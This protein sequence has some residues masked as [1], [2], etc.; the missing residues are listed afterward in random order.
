MASAAKRFRTERD[1]MGELR[2][3]ADAL[4]GA[5]T[6]RAV[7]NFPMSGR[8]MPRGFIRALGLIKASAAS[9]TPTSVCCRRAS[10]RRSTPP[11]CRSPRRARRAVPD[12]HLP[13]RLRH[14]V[15]HERQRGHRQRSRLAPPARQ[16]HPNDHVNLGQSS[17]DVIPTA[18]HVSAQLAI[19]RGPAAGAEAPARD[20]RPPRPKTFGKVV[21]TGRTHL[22]DA[23]PLTFAQEFGAWSAQLSS[24]QARIEDALQAPAPPADRRHRDRHRHQRRSALRQGDGEARCRR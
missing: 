16:V 7:D 14:L 21:K 20:H 23:M 1:S 2:V 8:P 4:W 22:M 24:A 5:Q 17:N 19:V 6:Q 12:R 3:P 9:S 10:R 13:D 18:I 11:R 15:E